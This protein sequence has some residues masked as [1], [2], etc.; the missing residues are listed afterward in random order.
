MRPRDALLEL[1]SPALARARRQRR[2]RAMH[3]V[4]R[5]VPHPELVVRTLAIRPR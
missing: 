3:P 5:P 1:I 4:P 2:V